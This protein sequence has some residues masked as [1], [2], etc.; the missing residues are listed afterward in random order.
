MTRQLTFHVAFYFARGF[1]G[2]RRALSPSPSL[3]L[4]LVLAGVTALAAA[5]ARAQ[6]SFDNSPATPR[7][8]A[9]QPPQPVQAPT[10]PPQGL[11]NRP[12]GLDL[13]KLAN[14]RPQPGAS[15]TADAGETQDFGVKPVGQLRPSEQLH[16]PTP[17]S[18]PGGKVIGTRQ[19]A[20]LM[21][22]Q[23]GAPS[24]LMLLHA[25]ASQRHLPNAI[26]VVPAAQGGGFD[27]QVQRDFGNYLQQA[28]G[29]D[30][31]RML[32]TY[33]SGVQCWG[34]YNAAL[35]A[36]RMGYTNVHWY[37]GGMEAW[38]QAGLTVMTA[39]EQGRQQGPQVQQVQ[40][41]D[42]GPQGQPSQPQ[43]QQVQPR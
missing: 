4:N 38:E 32:V 24:R 27:D 3:V 1:A 41:G 23:Q 14:T 42:P 30:R 33:C 43:R 5:P 22:E 10:Q 36:I 12:P 11:S 18:I 19:L 13:P 37:R 35:R 21:H 17:T 8:A 6:D 2:L 26:P 31:G 9:V 40:R 20:Q 28:T 16:A 29:G 7:R 25:I 15:G 34:S 39:S